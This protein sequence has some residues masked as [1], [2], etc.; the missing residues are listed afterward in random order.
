V[1]PP[2]VA[3]LHSPI[4]G[5]A[6]WG[7]LPEVLSALGVRAVVVDVADDDEPPYAQ[8]YVARAALQLAA[9][10]P[11]AP[12]VLVGHSGAGPLLPQ[13]GWARRAAGQ[14]VGGYV[15]LDAML[16]SPGRRSRLD[17]L[18]VT[19]P[20]SAAWLREH[21]RFPE[22]TDADLAT[23]VPDAAL[24]HALLASLRPRTL[25]FFTEPLPYPPDWP[26]APCGYLRTSPAYDSDLRQARAR[27]WPLTERGGGHFAALTDPEGVARDLLALLAQL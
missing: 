21:P 1:T 15:F 17:V 25:D 14:P 12:L 23:E 27:D 3:L 7:R 24:R 16:P 18:E 10:A 6:S 5:A 22:W 13:V 26:D 19:D 8:R 2:S 20:E 11:E 4:V 9:A